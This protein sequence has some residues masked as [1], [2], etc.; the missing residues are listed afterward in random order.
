MIEL[1]CNSISIIKLKYYQNK[2]DLQV[3][4]C[5]VILFVILK[6]MGLCKQKMKTKFSSVRGWTLEVI[7]L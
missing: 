1:N 2:I 6:K 7:K 5:F 4:Y 3:F